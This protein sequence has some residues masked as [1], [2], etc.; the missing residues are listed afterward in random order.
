MMSDKDNGFVNGK[1]PEV[2]CEKAGKKS[3]AKDGKFQFGNYNRYYGYRNEP[4]S[5]DVRLECFR[6]EWFAD[7]DVLDIGCNVGHVTLTIA[8]DFDPHQI[9]GIDIDKNLIKS[10]IKNI[11]HY[12]YNKSSYHGKRKRL[13]THSISKKI[14]SECD[15]PALSSDPIIPKQNSSKQIIDT[16]VSNQLNNF[17]NESS[18]DHKLLRQS[19]E[20]CNGNMINEKFLDSSKVCRLITEPMK[21]DLPSLVGIKSS[22]SVN[23]VTL[24]ELLVKDQRNESNFAKVNNHQADS[25]FSSPKKFPKNVT[26]YAENYVLTDDKFLLNEKPIYNTILCLSVTKWIHLNYADDGLKR[27]F[28]RMYAQL[29][30]GGMLIIEPQPWSS[31][32]KKKF[33]SENMMKTFKTINLRPNQFNDYLISEVGFASFNLIDTPK[34]KSRGNHFKSK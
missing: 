28:K 13:E 29:K 30:P 14:N 15:K 11:R 32:K 7:K 12:V 6:K 2:S 20:S 4:M 34:H 26:F 27:S 23:E 9:V 31:Y 8:R 3:V 22:T 17:S 21:I 33:I 18:G 1:R 16:L 5:P 19:D 25:T 10:A 24:E